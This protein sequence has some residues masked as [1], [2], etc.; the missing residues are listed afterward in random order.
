MKGTAYNQKV[1]AGCH[2]VPEWLLMGVCFSLRFRREDLISI[3]E[4]KVGHVRD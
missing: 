1:I 3:D 2:L 4:K